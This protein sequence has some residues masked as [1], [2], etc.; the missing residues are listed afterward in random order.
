MKLTF[1]TNLVDAT[2]ESPTGS[3]GGGGADSWVN[4]SL[5]SLSEVNGLNTDVD[6]RAQLS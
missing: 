5:H 3:R 4:T 2:S 1:K 6:E